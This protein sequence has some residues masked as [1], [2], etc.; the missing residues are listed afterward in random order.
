MLQ[1]GIQIDRRPPTVLRLSTDRLE[2]EIRGEVQL[3]EEELV[4][5][6]RPDLVGLEGGLREVLEVQGD[7]D[8]GA[9]DD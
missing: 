6:D 2:D 1:E 4:R 3:I 7:D 8:V 5:S 9:P